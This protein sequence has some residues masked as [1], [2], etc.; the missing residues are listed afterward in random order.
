MAGSG[1]IGIWD[2]AVGDGLGAAGVAVGDGVAGFGAGVVGSGDGGFGVAMGVVGRGVAGLAVWG[3]AV[4]GGVAVRGTGVV[5]LAVGGSVGGGACC[6]WQATVSS[7]RA[8]SAAI[9][10]TANN[11]TIL[12]IL[13]VSSQEIVVRTKKRNWSICH[14]VA[15]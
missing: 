11:L 15:V 14:P 8:V 2:I 3:L 12:T 4:G 5:G 10:T 13:M 7:A 1:V 6:T 9:K